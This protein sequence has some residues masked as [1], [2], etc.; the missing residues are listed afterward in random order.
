M[1][2]VKK[3]ITSPVNL[4]YQGNICDI[5]LNFMLC[6]EIK[7]PRVVN[8]VQPYLGLIRNITLITKV[9]LGILINGRYKHFVSILTRST[10]PW[11]LSSL[12]S[13]K[14]CYSKNSTLSSSSQKQTLQKFLKNMRQLLN[15]NHV[16]WKRI[17]YSW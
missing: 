14:Y 13:L 3:A 7:T 17:T 6:L 12:I 2:Y 9:L 4:F 5:T 15:D 8:L 16:H 11:N 10:S 1:D